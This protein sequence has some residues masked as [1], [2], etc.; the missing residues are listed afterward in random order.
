MSLSRIA[1]RYKEIKSMK[2]KIRNRKSV[3]IPKRNNSENRKKCILI[4]T[5]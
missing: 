3:E 2:K 5:G 1:E 4:L